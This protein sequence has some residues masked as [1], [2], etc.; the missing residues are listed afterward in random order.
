MR[1]IKKMAAMLMLGVMLCG[2]V[3]TANA[4]C[5]HP[6][7]TNSVET[8]TTYKSEGSHTY[9]TGSIC[10]ITRVTVNYN[11]VCKDCGAVLGSYS[12]TTIKHSA[13]H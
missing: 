10:Y 8:S 11:A 6:H 4:A 1:K 13:S 2:S 5:G 7:G 3:L 12:T 9:G